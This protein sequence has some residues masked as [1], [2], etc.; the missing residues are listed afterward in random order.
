MTCYCARDVDSDLDVSSIISVLTRQML[1]ESV[2]TRI[3]ALH[4]L[5]HLYVNLPSKVFVVVVIVVV[6]VII[7]IV[8]VMASLL[9]TGCTISICPARYFICF[10]FLVVFFYINN[11]TMPSLDGAGNLTFL[12]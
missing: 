2:Q 10:W 5:Y 8:V 7:A 9:Y 12:C 1:H 3:T 4:W 11:Y 6:L